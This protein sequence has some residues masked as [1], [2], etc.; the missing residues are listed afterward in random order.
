M[1]N[2]ENVVIPCKS[3]WTDSTYVSNK[4]NLKRK[5][6]QFHIK[7]RV[8]HGTSEFSKYPTFLWTTIWNNPSHFYKVNKLFLIVFFAK[9]PNSVRG[10]AVTWGLYIETLKV[11]NF[12]FGFF[13]NG[14]SNNSIYRKRFQF[15]K[16][17]KKWNQVSAKL[18]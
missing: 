5:V 4:N 12:L 15:L 18:L 16:K 1:E 14:L 9:V 6:L 3:L 11:Y 2:D 8:T 13:W 17:Q 10:N 7:Y